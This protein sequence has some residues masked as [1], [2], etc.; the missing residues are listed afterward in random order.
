MNQIA[1]IAPTASGKTALS[2]EV[3]KHTNSIILS[4]DSLSVYKE[5]NI[6]SAKPTKKE[7]N[8]IVHFGIDEIYPY[9]HFDVVKFIDVY[10]KAKKYA[11]KNNKNLIIVG[12]TGFY[13]K[14][15]ING[16]SII[17]EITKSTK[18]W[19][20]KMLLNLDDAYTYMKNLD[21][22]YM[23][24]IAINDKYRIEKSLTIYKQTKTIPTKYFS[25]NKPTPIIDNIKIFEI[26]W[27]ME[28]LRKRIEKRTD[29]MINDGII[30]EVIYLEK[31]YGRSHA[32]MGSIGIVEV[33]E[34]IDGKI[35][36][37]KLIEK[38][39]IN[40]YRLAKRQKT[41]NKGQFD[42]Y[43]KASLQELR[44]KLLQSAKN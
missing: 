2:I 16:L 6:A 38:I 41:F 44:K 24:N 29:I 21:S 39:I 33:L 27:T 17:P 23:E 8:G 43:L 1:I 26:D 4:L 10:K 19:V 32:A 3:A 42:V 14:A 15:M 20:D 9:E 37:K 12:G 35:N 34:Y 22:I 18:Q 31:R 7:M 28:S 13:L 5:I 36:K 25:M 30:D 40:T 11:L